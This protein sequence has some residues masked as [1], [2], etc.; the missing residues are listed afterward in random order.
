MFFSRTY[1]GCL[2][3]GKKFE[4]HEVPTEYGKKGLFI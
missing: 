4:G 3:F 1:T 2:Y